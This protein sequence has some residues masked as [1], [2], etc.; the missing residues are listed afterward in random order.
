MKFND[1]NNKL[2]KRYFQFQALAQSV[3]EHQPDFD[4]LKGSAQDISQ[5][6]GDGR[7]ASYA[8]Q[9]LSRYQTLA[10]SVQEQVEKCEQ[11]IEDHEGYLNKYKDSVEW[12]KAQQ[13]ELSECSDMPSDNEALEA[14]LATMQALTDDNEDGLG[15]FNSALESGERLY[16]NTSNEG[17]EGIRR[18]L[19]SL[20]D[21]W[22]NYNDT[23]H[24][25][26]RNLDSCRMQWS[27]FDENFEQLEKWVSES[28]ELLEEDADPKNTLQEKKAALQHYRVCLILLSLIIIL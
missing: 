9:L 23:L 28:T 11:N 13:Q 20:R 19:R 7:T 26:Q 22:E 27:S 2:T 24:E 21:Q 15:R 10:E 17:R 5:S 1:K 8:G 16:P 12:I 25:T 6:T 3:A 4:K 14:K 18:E